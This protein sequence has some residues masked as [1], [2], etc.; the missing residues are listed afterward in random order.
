MSI[1]EIFTGEHIADVILGVM[2]LEG[3]VLI[4]LRHRTGV[5]ILDIVLTL[6]PGIMLALALRAALTDASWVWIALPLAFAFPVH[7]ADLRRRWR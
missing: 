6:L 7:I 4:A 1:G 3:I 2:I 5:R